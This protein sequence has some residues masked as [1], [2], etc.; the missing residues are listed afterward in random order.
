[1]WLV[2]KMMKTARWPWSEWVLLFMLLVMMDGHIH[3]I[4]VIAATDTLSPGQCLAQG[5][6]ITTSDGKYF[7]VMQTD[8]NCV[9]YAQG[10]ALWATMTNYLTGFQA[11]MLA[12][13]N[14]VLYNTTND[15]IWASNT[16][17]NAGAYAQV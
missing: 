8:G 12:T 13:G 11:C 10:N 9:L 6:N 15:I 2:T 17:G 1:M 14:L 4:G 3:L 16:T 7:M 5:Q